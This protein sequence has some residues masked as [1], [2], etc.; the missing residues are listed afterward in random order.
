MHAAVIQTPGSLWT[1]GLG[2][3]PAARQRTGAPQGS[4]PQMQGAGT[5]ANPQR[6][7]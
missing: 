2:L 4:A 6:G 7:T 1:V 5:L 3:G